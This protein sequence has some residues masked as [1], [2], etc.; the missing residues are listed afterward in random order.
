MPT[1]PTSRFARLHRR[2][3]L[4]LGLGALAA[5]LLP[6]LPARAAIPAGTVL[7]VG[8]QKGGSQSVVEAAGIL[9][10]LPYR[11]EWSQF[12]AAAPLLEALNAGAIDTGYAGDAPTTFALAAGTSAR[13]IAAVRSNPHSTTILVPGASAIREVADLKGKTIGTGRG[14][15]GHYL[16]LAAL[17][18]NGLTPGDVRIAFLLPSDAK[19]AL[20]AGSIDAWSTWGI[21]VSQALL[22]DGARAVATG[23]GLMSGL[24]YQSATLDA[25]AGKRDALAD[26]VHRTAA[27]RLWA[28][29]NSDGYADIWAKAVGVDPAIAR[30]TFGVEQARPVA[31]DGSV[32]ADQQATSDLWREFGIIPARL[33][34]GAIFDPGF[35]S[36]LPA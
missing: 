8:D 18:A 24:S 28:L 5:G 3:T 23:N 17:K 7:R 31:I 36:A 10:D 14:S 1:S 22:V 6:P 33:D 29:R 15:I 16:V 2:H 27:A 21:Y 25:I 9:A 4:A 19:S 13:I 20:A 30:H 32:I 12:P 34:A 11:I 35:N 26:F